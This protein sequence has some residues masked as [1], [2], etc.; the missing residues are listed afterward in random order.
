MVPKSEH[1]IVRLERYDRAAICS[2]TGKPSIR[3]VTRAVPAR[4]MDRESRR[5]RASAAAPLS[6]ASGRVVPGVSC[7]CRMRVDELCPHSTGICELGY[8][9]RPLDSTM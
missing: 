2:A 9:V 6:T 4:R 7:A 1:M 3:M 5:Q 8:G